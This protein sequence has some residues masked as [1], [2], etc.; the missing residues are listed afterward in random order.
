MSYGR[1]RAGGIRGLFEKN[2]TDS[3][4]LHNLEMFSINR[5][6]PFRRSVNRK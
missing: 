2:L 5:N 3:F 6:F 1:S 4:V